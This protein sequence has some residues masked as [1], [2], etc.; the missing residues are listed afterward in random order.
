MFARVLALPLGPWVLIALG[1]CTSYARAH[2]EL[3]IEQPESI[4]ECLTP[5]KAN[6]GLPVY[7]AV[8]VKMKTGAEVLVQLTF[9]AA[10]KSPSVKVLK[11]T[12]AD[13]FIDSVKDFVKHYRLP[14]L[15]ASNAPVRARQEFVFDPG[16]GRKIVYGTITDELN[17]IPKSCFSMPKDGPDYPKEAAVKDEAGTL[18]A[19]LSFD[20]PDEAPKV[21]IL[22][23]A[24]SRS[25]AG[26]VRSHLQRYR[27]TCPLPDGK[28]V[29]ATQVFNFVLSDATRYAFKDIEFREFLKIV[30]PVG[31]T[32]AKF[33]L[34]QMSCPFDLSVAARMPYSENVVGEYGE[35]NPQ[36]K[37]FIKWVK[38]LTVRVAHKVEPFMFDKTMKLSVPCLVLD[39]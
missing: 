28:P 6:L 16:D 17:Q 34:N 27:F 30:D 19:S 13:E 38:Q 10:D 22:Y 24:R 1:L 8:E 11:S 25:L 21:S 12:G 35:S 36:R 31:L 20:Q 9:E 5:T 3:Q 39:L 2:S 29:V 33:D 26:T 18:L 37:R 32:N 15:S 14:C 7:P 23:N 4:L